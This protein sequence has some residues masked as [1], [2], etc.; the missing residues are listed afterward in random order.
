MEDAENIKLFVFDVDG[1][2]TPGT[3]IFG[4]DG[5]AY[6]T[7]NVHDGMAIGLL[8]QM[9][10]MTGLLTG[11]KSDIVRIRAEELKMDF[12]L[13]G[14]KNKLTAL[15]GILQ[16]KGLS[17]KE[18][19]FMGDDLNDLPLFDKVGISG[20]PSDGCPENKAAAD[21]VSQYC[22]GVGAVREFIESILKAAGKWEEAVAS[23]SK[24]TEISSVQ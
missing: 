12:L 3:L 9:G 16:V 8:H 5:E 7:F 24:E 17:R 4:P 23:F 15:D 2:L 6:K 21:F 10:Y 18:V 11:R 13:T 14:V 19:A 20:C 22:G 1:T